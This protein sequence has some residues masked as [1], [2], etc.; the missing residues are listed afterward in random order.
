MAT[1]EHEEATII[2]EI[3]YSILE[4]RRTSVPVTKQ[5]RGDLYQLVD[6]QRLNSS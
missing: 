5:R 4:Q 2:A 3:D 1:T 6:L